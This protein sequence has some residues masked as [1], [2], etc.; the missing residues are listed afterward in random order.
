MPT[1][2]SQPRKQRKALAEMPLHLRHKLMTAKLS[3][4]L[5]RKLGV[6][7][8]PVRV[9]DT[10]VVL[11]GDFK[12]VSGKVVRVD[13]KRVRIYVENVTR[14]NS[15]GETVYYPLHPSKVMITNVDTSDKFRQRII[16]RRK[17]KQTAQ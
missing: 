14:T 12:G 11:R 7:R 17:A 10:V 1:M 5:S 8:L 6:S 9:G 4:E 16:E 3:P 15:R 2:S 13:L